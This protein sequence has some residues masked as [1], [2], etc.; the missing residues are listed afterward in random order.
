MASVEFPSLEAEVSFLRG[1]TAVTRI[2]DEIIEDCLE[3]GL[4]LDA[5]VDVYLTQCARL[6]N[7][8]AGFVGLRGSKGPVLTRVLGVLGVDVFEATGWSGCRPLPEGRML[9]CAPLTLGRLEL[10]T[11]GLV[12]AG[13]FDDGGALVMKLVAAMAD[14]LDNAVLAFIAL[15]DGAHVL[16]KLDDLAPE[17]DPVTGTRARIGRYELVTPLGTGGMAQVLVARTRGPE[18]LGRLVALKRILPQ[19]VSDP[20]MVKQFL[21]EARIGLRLSHSNLVTIHDFGESQGAYFLVMELVRGVDF[22]RLLKTLRPSAAV[23]SAVVV[24]AL[25]G[26]HAAHLA[27]GEDGRPLQ[28]VHRDLSPHNLMVGFDGRVKVLDFGVAKARA[29]RTVTLPGIVKG[30]PLYMSPEQAL[31]RRLDARSDLFAMGLILY[32]AFTGK[33]AFDRGDDVASM[34]AICD[35]RLSRPASIHPKLWGV[36]EQALAKRPE[37]RFAHA[38]QMAEALTEACPPARDGEVGQLVR[39][40]FPERLQ[41]FERLERVHLAS[42]PPTSPTRATPVVPA[43]GPAR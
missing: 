33:R 30:K 2:A 22:D 25:H 10:G 15:A 41:G 11:M 16:E 18:G 39:T 13:R 3:R 32:E 26:L 27:R 38:Q 34:E 14:Q 28:L 23:V 5:A 31:G 1:L 40:H 29:Q 4:D 35:D 36:L 8:S 6:V 43:K 12:V 9:F 7:A 42:G 24:Q 37:D 21:D 19:L 17:E 20:D